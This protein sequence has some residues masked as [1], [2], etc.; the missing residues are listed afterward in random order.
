VIY[1]DPQTKKT[2]SLLPGDLVRSKKEFDA[3]YSVH[4]GDVGVVDYI[5]SIAIRL[6]FPW[7][8]EHTKEDSIQDGMALSIIAMFGIEVIYSKEAFPSLGKMVITFMKE[9]E[10]VT[11]EQIIKEFNHKFMRK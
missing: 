3:P 6:L 10:K 2:V 4:I 7:T 5:G 1:M 8:P 11:D 9:F